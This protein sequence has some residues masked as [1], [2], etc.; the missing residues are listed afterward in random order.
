[1]PHIAI[2]FFLYISTAD[3]E[4]HFSGWCMLFITE[5]DLGEEHLLWT[6]SSYKLRE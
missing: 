4:Y 5:P 6:V 1:M 2:Y 3:R